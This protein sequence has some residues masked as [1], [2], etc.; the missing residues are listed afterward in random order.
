MSIY[1]LSCIVT[2]V[3]CLLLT[4]CE[5]APKE[6]N[7]YSYRQENLIKPLLDQFST[8]TGIK[9]NLVTG[10]ADALFQRLETE[11]ENTPADILLTTDAGRLYRAK[12][13]GLLQPVDSEVLTTAVPA[14]LRDPDKTW[15]GL[16]YRARA[17][18]YNKDKVDPGKI[19]GYES[20]TAPEWKGRICVRSSGNIYNQSLLAAMIISQG[21]AAAESWARGIVANMAREPSGNDRSQMEGAVVGECDVAIVN[22]YYFGNWLASTDPKDQEMAAKL[23]LLFPNQADRGTHINVSGAG[24]TKH[25]KHI[26][27]AVKLLEYL[28]SDS[29]QRWYADV[30]QEYPVKPG[31]PVSDIVRAWGYPFKAEAINLNQLGEYNEAAVKIFDRAGWK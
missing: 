20:L 2:A 1:R 6:V 25:A 4:A 23:G 12:Q 15:F 31:I 24:V 7:V 22:T 26:D 30:N 28:V 3:L 9:V 11:G 18:V 21:E 27:N 13:A 10:E 29:A 14:D 19:A 16:S 17:I 8:E 5:Q